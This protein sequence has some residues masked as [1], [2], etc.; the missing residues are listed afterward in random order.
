[1]VAE[2]VRMTSLVSS[3]KPGEWQLQFLL[4]CSFEES[5]TEFGQTWD[6]SRE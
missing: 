2:V 6:L 5:S 3:G 4:R 1:M